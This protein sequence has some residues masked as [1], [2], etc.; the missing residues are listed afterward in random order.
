[1]SCNENVI[2]ILEKKLDKVNWSYLSYNENAIHIVIES[3]LEELSSESESIN[4]ISVIFCGN[5]DQ[6]S[7]INF[8]LFIS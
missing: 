5:F 7:M 4:D 6:V 3:L 2:H 1:M 8:L